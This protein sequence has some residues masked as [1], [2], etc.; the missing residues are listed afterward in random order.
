MCGNIMCDCGDVG[1]NHYIMGLPIL[2]RN[3][4]NFSIL[5]LFNDIHVAVQEYY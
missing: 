1:I 4:I 2:L 3:G 5:L